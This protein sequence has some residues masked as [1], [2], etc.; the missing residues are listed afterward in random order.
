MHIKITIC[1]FVGLL[2]YALL[3]VEFQQQSII[4]NG[5]PFMKKQRVRFTTYVLAAGRQQLL[6]YITGSGQ[7]FHI[8]PPVIHK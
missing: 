1:I 4:D 6:R 8:G 5:S 3:T 2:N 7:D